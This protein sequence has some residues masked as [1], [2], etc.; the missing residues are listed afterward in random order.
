MVDLSSSLHD[1]TV[2]DLIQ[3]WGGDF[4]YLIVSSRLF[5]MNKR[6]NESGILFISFK[7]CFTSISFKLIVF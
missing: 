1:L 2:D 7:I 4:K 6:N 3:N 5:N